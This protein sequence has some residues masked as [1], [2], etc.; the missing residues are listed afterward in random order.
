MSSRSPCRIRIGPLELLRSLT[1]C[2]TCRERESAGAPKPEA[3]AATLEKDDSRISAGTGRS[4]EIAARAAAERAAVRNDARRVDVLVLPCPV[5]RRQHAFGDRLLRRRSVGAAVAGIF[6]EQ[7]TDTPAARLLELLR[8]VIDQFAVAMREHQQRRPAVRAIAIAR[9]I[10][11][12]DAAEGRRSARSAR[13]WRPWR[14]TGHRRHREEHRSLRER[15]TTPNM[16]PADRP[17]RAR[18]RSQSSGWA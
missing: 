10:P 11:R 8:P 13:H 18:R 14:R 9:Q 3:N 6:D 2:R 4:S 5:V 1:R 7:H 17:R 15:T 12:F 16:R